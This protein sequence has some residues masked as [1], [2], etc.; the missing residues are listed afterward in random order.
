MPWA[1]VGYVVSV[2]SRHPWLL[3]NPF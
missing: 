3:G 1:L 2:A